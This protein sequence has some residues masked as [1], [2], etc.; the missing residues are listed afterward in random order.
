MRTSRRN[1]ETQPFTIKS[2]S[3]YLRVRAKSAYDAILNT[4]WCLQ[5]FKVRQPLRRI[6]LLTD[7]QC[8]ITCQSSLDDDQMYC[9][10]VSVAIE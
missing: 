2:A 3:R 1:L 7:E 5:V 10:V 6:I 4:A 9:L 8:K